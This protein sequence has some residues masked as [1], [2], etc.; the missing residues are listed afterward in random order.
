MWTS[1]LVALAYVLC[2]PIDVE[3]EKPHTVT[4]IENI[5]EHDRVVAYRQVCNF[6][7]PPQFTRE[8]VDSA[9]LEKSLD[10]RQQIKT[11]PGAN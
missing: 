8:K 7:P 6:G 10:S 9:E 1:A 5:V 3:F 4:W 2:T 11:V